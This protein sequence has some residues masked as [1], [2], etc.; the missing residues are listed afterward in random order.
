MKILY[1]IFRLPFKWEKYFHVDGL[2][3]NCFCEPFSFDITVHSL[4]SNIW[5]PRHLNFSSASYKS[6]RDAGEKY[7]LPEKGF[8]KSAQY[9]EV[10]N[11]SQM[12]LAAIRN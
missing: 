1:R 11:L 10:L 12:F 6:L 8:I 7:G 9:P 2:P 5:K 4:I 3:I